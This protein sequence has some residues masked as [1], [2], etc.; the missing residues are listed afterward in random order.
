MHSGGRVIPRDATS[1]MDARDTEQENLDLRI[2]LVMRIDVA[3]QRDTSCTL[4]QENQLE[5]P[6]SRQAWLSLQPS[7]LGLRIEISRS[8]SSSLSSRTT[9]PCYTLWLLLQM[10]KNMGYRTSDEDGVVRT[11]WSDWKRCGW[12]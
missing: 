10:H 5:L 4:T 2:A 1:F 9:R 12:R 11:S 6:C 8:A 7:R 3:R